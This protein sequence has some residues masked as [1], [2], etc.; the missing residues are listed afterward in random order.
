MASTKGTFQGL[1][2]GAVVAVASA[3]GADAPTQ[4]ITA[5]GMKFEAPAAWKSIKPSSPMRKAVLKIDPVTGDEDGAELIVYVFPGGGGGTDQNLDRWRGFFKD[6][7]A[8]ERKEV[9]G[10]NVDVTRAETSGHYIAPVM[11]GSSERHDKPNYHLLGAIVQSGGLGYFLR[12][13]GPEKTVVAARPAFDT[14]LASIQ[15]EGQ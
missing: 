3:L 7:P 12:M 5:E 4:T 14:L 15:V 8:M 10:K 6:K 9:K 1:T 11:P 13:V 2:L